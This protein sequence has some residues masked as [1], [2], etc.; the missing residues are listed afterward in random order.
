MD[1]KTF[2]VRMNRP[3]VEMV[4]EL[5]G[6]YMVEV[7]D[8][9]KRLMVQELKWVELLMVQLAQVMGRKDF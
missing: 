2:E 3:Q 1:T 4:H 7:K 9:P 8:V 5:L 6:R